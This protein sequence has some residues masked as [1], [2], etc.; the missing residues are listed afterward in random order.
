MDTCLIYCTSNIIFVVEV[1]LFVEF[2]EV[3]LFFSLSGVMFTAGCKQKFLNFIYLRN[4][5]YSGVLYPLPT[6]TWLN[7][8]GNRFTANYPSY[9]AEWPA[10]AA[11]SV[12]QTKLLGSAEDNADHMG[13]Y[14]GV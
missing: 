11:L 2:S 7:A 14:L 10:G 3:S 5:L 12:R 13:L 9:P 1:H 4:K 8:C 6:V